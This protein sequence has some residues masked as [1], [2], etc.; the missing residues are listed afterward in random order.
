[1]ILYHGT[2]IQFDKIELSKCRPNKDFGKGFYLTSIESQAIDMAQ[3]R[4]NF[5][6]TGSPIVQKYDWNEKKDDIQV[7][8]FE[9]ISVEWAKFIVENRDRKNKE[10][11]GYDLVIGPIADDGVVYQI[12]RYL[13]NIITINDL[14]KELKHKKLNNQYCF[15]TEKAILHL[16]RL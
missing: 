9:G 13:Q 12:N 4:C 15:C 5:D 6:E 16:K 3:R 10:F 11:H 8:V 7:L 1:M 2:N 14:V